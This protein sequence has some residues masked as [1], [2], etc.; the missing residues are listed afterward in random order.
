MEKKQPE[1]KDNGARFDQQQCRV[2]IRWKLITSFDFQMFRAQTFGVW[3]LFL[4]SGKSKIL[5]FNSSDQLLGLMILKRRNIIMI[6]FPGRRYD[7][8]VRT[9]SMPEWG[10][11]LLIDDHCRCHHYSHTLLQVFLSSTNQLVFNFSIILIF[12]TNA[13]NRFAVPE[14]TSKLC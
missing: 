8:L 13:M 14:L 10:S 11:S 4:S 9:W 6:D 5:A 12:S 3:L 7:P 1:A 2:S